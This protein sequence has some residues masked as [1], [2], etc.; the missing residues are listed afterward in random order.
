M[1]QSDFRELS[2]CLKTAREA[3]GLTQRELA[4]R[5]GY[6]SAQFISNWER[7]VGR[8]PLKIAPR[9][10]RILDIQPETYVRLLMI[11][12][13]RHLKRNLTGPKDC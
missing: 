3:K 10:L 4:E 13:M 2:E 9:I 12:S 8:I 6:S 5:L 7:D 1:R 11:G